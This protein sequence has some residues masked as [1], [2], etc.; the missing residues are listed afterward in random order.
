MTFIDLADFPLPIFNEDVEAEGF[1]EEARRLQKLMIESDGFLISCPE[2]NSMMP[3]AI[4]NAI[5]W[6]SRKQEGQT[7][8]QAFKGKNAVVMSASPGGLGGI[9]G[10]PI[11]RL[12]LSNIGVN[13]LAQ[14][15]AVS[16][17]HEELDE[18][19]QLRSE[20]LASEVKDLGKALVESLS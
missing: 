16:K 9:R 6:A 15:K 3:A 12:L 5:D 7:P 17:V 4:K 10:L 18:S 20:K 11:F 8:L 1:P 14:Q 2:Y 19:G 13:V